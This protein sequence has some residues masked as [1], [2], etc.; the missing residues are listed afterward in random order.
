MAS[1]YMKKRD[2]WDNI[3]SATI[4]EFKNLPAGG[5]VC[6]ILK[7]ECGTSKNGNEMLVLSL[8]I[9]EG[10]YAGYYMDG[11]NA[12]KEKAKDGETPKWYCKMYQLTEGNSEKFYKGLI[13]TI[14]QSNSGYKW[15]FD[16]K[17]LKNKLIGVIF[18]EEE[19]TYNGEIKVNVKPTYTR[20]ID[21]IRKG[22][23]NVPARKTAPIS[24]ELISE[25]VDDD[26]PF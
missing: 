21:K 1:L 10:E 16:E 19:Y 3:E 14:E 4:G 9:A 7:A 24:F 5:Y 23:F 11:F 20:A 25:E 13:T 12:R 17:S 22:D 6:K 2:N 8:D 15:D 26:L 18:G